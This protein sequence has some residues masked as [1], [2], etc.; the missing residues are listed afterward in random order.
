MFYEEF[1]LDD[2]GDVA[3]EYKDEELKIY[4]YMSHLSDG[5]ANLAEVITHEWLHGLFDWAT[6]GESDEKYMVDANKDHFIMKKLNF[7]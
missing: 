4:Y 3:A 6:E 5:Y 2:S 7:D 1:I